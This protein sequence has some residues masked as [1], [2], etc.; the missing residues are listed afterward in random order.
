MK[1]RNKSFDLTSLQLK[2]CHCLSRNLGYQ[3]SFFL[4]S[5]Y[6]SKL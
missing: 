5:K 2:N 6:T 1:K 3:R 4:A